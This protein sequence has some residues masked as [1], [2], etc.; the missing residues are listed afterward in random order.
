MAVRVSGAGGGF[1]REAGKTV[2]GRDG[3]LSTAYSNTPFVTH[4]HLYHRQ[5]RWEAVC[6]RD[7]G[8]DPQR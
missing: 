5:R 6:Q 2:M 8:D 4:L 7:E 3:Y 1:G